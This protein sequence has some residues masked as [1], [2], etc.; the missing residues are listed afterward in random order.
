MSKSNLVLGLVIFA[1]LLA[2]AVGVQRYLVPSYI[3]WM[4]DWDQT[5][6]PVAELSSKIGDY[7]R[8]LVPALC[9]LVGF[10]LWRFRADRAAGVMVLQTASL[11]VTL[12]LLLQAA[13]FLDLALA[14]YH[15]PG[16]P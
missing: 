14:I 15:H 12:F 2:Y 4:K 1:L 5:I 3:N 9:L 11:L 10:G 13:V 6:G 8:I 16:R 7:G